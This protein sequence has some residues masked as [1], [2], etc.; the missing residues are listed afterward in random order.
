MKEIA[1]F[2]LLGDMDDS[3]VTGAAQ[4]VKKRARAR[5]WL[6]VAACAAVVL[7][8]LPLLRGTG[9]KVPAL[10]SYALSAQGGIDNV[11]AQEFSAGGG[12]Q[13]QAMLPEELRQAMLD[14]GFSEDDATAF[15]WDHPM[16][17]ANWWKFYHSYDDGDRTLETLAEYAGAPSQAAGDHDHLVMPL[18]MLP[19]DYGVQPQYTGEVV[20]GA[21]EPD[22]NAPAQQEAL[23]AYQHLI[24][25]F[26][27]EYGPGAYPDWYGGAYITGGTHL[28]VNIPHRIDEQQTD[29]SLYLRIQDWAESK[30]VG[31]GGVKYSLN[32]LLALQAQVTALPELLALPNWGCGIDQQDGQVTLY[33]PTADQ[34]LFAA[35]AGLYPADDAIRVSV[36]AGQSIV[37]DDTN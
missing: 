23:D 29:K 11:T 36:D 25:R 22:P 6:P 34:A 12:D 28:I 8:A 18:P 15:A 14:A 35:L 26:E 33:L 1:L 16:T 10:H 4:P 30:A 19:A 13:D 2:Q 9:K 7:L 27:A 17:W 20:G 32:E 21:A 24:S 3:F 31:F 37:T 5:V